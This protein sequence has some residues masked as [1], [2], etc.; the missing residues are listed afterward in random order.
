M[1]AHNCSDLK[2]KDPDHVLNCT[3]GSITFDL[4][5][6][7]LVF[8]IVLVEEFNVEIRAMQMA[9]GGSLVKTSKGGCNRRHFQFSTKGHQ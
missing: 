2:I 3:D 6:G 5:Y 9:I 7:V 1:D 8:V 4:S